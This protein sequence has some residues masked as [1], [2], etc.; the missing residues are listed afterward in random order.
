MYKIISLQDWILPGTIPILE[1][2]DNK[3]ILIFQTT[4]NS[5]KQINST[6]LMYSVY[7]NGC[8]S[9]PQPVYTSESADLFASVVSYNNNVYL[10]WQKQGMVT[11]NQS[12]DTMLGE[13]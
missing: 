12:V 13:A 10:V 11:D 9:L 8:F 3:T 4:D 6:V 5:R 1:Q 7:E 2:I